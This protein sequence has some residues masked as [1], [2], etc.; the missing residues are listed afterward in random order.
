MSNPE[1]VALKIVVLGNSGAGK[2]SLVNRWIT[3]SH[4]KSIT[5]TVGANHQ[6]KTIEI[7]KKNVDLFIWDTAGQE[8]FQALTPLYTRSA[9][10]AI[11]CASITDN[12]SFESLDLWKELVNNSCETPPP[13][14]LAVN[15]IDLASE[16]TLSNEAI[17][18]KFSNQ[19][20]GLFFTSSITGEGV[21]EM[22]V[23]AGKL[24]MN[25]TNQVTDNDAKGLQD[26][27]TSNKK[28]RCC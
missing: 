16:K 25:Y 10:C 5:P 26:L 19:F 2:T 6:K 21:E 1:R 18:D 17:E 15:K 11:I 14:I 22:F 20:D 9:A 13:T 4:N 24:G 7:E 12:D 3:G 23:Q 8:Q 27:S 28:S